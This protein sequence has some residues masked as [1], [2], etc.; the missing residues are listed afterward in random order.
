[1]LVLQTLPPPTSNVWYLAYGS[2][3]AKSKFIHDRGIVP[4]ATA[5]VLVPGW[6]L[7]MDS[8]G[9]PYSEPSFGSITPIPDSRNEK[10]TELLGTAY[11]LTPEMYTKVIASEGGGIAY[12]EIEVRA[13]RVIDPSGSDLEKQN[14]TFAVRSLI[15]VLKHLARPSDR[16]LGLIRTGAEEAQMPD[17]YQKFLARIPTYTKPKDRLR[18]I[19]ASLFLAFW[20]PIMSMM[21][22]ITKA[23]LKS[24]GKANAPRWVIL[25]VRFVVISMWLY[26]D[27]VHSP[28]WG[29]GDGLDQS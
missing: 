2:N 4:L 22:K 20:V 8:A 7:T 12:A 23:A 16:Y 6:T 3:L 25:L 15:T 24:S 11:L 1:M 14:E 17:A 19:G 27:Y 29:R 28:I 13:S 26:H 9:V 21:E 10:N 5:V 18:M